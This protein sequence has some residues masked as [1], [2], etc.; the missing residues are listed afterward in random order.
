MRSKIGKRE[1]LYVPL[2]QNSPDP[3]PNEYDLG[4]D[5]FAAFDAAMSHLHFDAAN[6]DK[7][8]VS[9]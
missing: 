8:F 5:P 6:A 9:E 3:R 1:F 2:Q 7:W 4:S